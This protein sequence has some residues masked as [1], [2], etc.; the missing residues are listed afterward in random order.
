MK[1]IERYKINKN[2]YLISDELRPIW[3]LTEK[4][5]VYM[6]KAIVSNKE[7]IYI[8]STINT[9]SR[10][11]QHKYRVNLLKYKNKFYE[12]VLENGWE[13]FEF[14]I[15]EYVNSSLNNRDEKEFL[16]N[17][18]QEYL[19]NYNPN[20]NINNYAASLR[21]YRH[22]IETKNKYNYDRK[23]KSLKSIDSLKIRPDISKETILKLK[24]HKRMG[25]KVEIYTKEDELIKVCNTIVEAANYLGLS[26][27]T[28]SNYIK[29]GNLWNNSYY[30]R[31]KF[32]DSPAYMSKYFPL[33][34]E[35]ITSVIEDIKSHMSYS[36]FEVY[37]ENV[38]IFRFNSI[39]RASKYLNISKATLTKYASEKKLWKN[40]FTFK[41]YRNLSK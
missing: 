22:S 10:F 33:D 1:C 30:I 18:E 12:F 15:L 3:P 14:I 16:F 35:N 7:F 25:K 31:M 37:K 5:S 28:T 13:C 38:L 4:S 41:L 9:K 6:Y 27:S 8:G 23:G 2:G 39:T 34:E 36:V 20:L 24:S 19:D 29:Y 26:H 17:L 11:R 21:G 40:E 32:L